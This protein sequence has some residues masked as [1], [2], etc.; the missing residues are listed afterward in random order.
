M[1]VLTLL[2]V[3]NLKRAKILERAFNFGVRLPKKPPYIPSKVATKIQ[4]HVTT[5]YSGS[6]KGL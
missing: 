3:L 6:I 1:Y 2:L 4:A 5:D